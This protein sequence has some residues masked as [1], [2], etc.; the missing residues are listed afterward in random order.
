MTMMMV[1]VMIMMMIVMMVVMSSVVILITLS[2]NQ[3]ICDIVRYLY[4][5]ST[6]FMYY[7]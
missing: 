3:C 2:V 6:Y 1:A 4:D 7:R 5:V